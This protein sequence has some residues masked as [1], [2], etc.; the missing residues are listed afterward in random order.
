MAIPDLPSIGKSL[1]RLRTA[2]GLSLDQLSEKSG[3]SKSMLSQVENENVNPTV[4]LMWKIAHALGVSLNDIV[5]PKEDRVIE[6]TR[7]EHAP[8]LHDREGKWKIQIIS[9]LDMVEILE[10]YIIEIEKGGELKSDPHF[11]GTEE[12]LTVLKGKAIVE[13]ERDSVELHEF[14]TAKYKADTIHCIKNSSD[15]K[16]CAYLVVRYK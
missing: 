13:I 7:K 11:P 15:E 14:D 1:R 5:G 3:V 9:S 4:A 2:K 16:L 12:I 10:L 6:V 8:Y